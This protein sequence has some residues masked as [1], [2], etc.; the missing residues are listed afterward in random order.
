MKTCPRIHAEKGE[1]RMKTL[2]IKDL[3]NC[4]MC[5]AKAIMRK[6]ASK[7]F[8]IACTK[9]DC[10]TGWT[11]KPDAIVRWYNI[12]LILMKKHHEQEKAEK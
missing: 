6:N 8:Q 2:K 11:T 7:D 12:T 5:G 4:P 1:K 10:H 9:C 3:A